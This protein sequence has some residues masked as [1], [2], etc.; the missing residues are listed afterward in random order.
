MSTSTWLTL[1]VALLLVQSASAQQPLFAQCGG[2]G[3][4]GST[5]CVS[6][7]VCTKIND[8][9]YQCLAAGSTTTT[10]IPVTVTTTLAPSTSTI[11]SST[12][13]TSTVPITTSPG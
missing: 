9:Y 5:T 2:I 1:S 3:W 13:S 8:Y 4:T 6:G 12:V 11:P 10:S 7:A